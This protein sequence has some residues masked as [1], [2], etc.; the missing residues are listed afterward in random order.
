MA[1]KVGGFYRAALV[2]ADQGVLDAAAQLVDVQEEL[3]VWR[4][5]L[6]A[7]MGQPGPEDD[8]VV[9]MKRATEMILKLMQL[10]SRLANVAGDTL[11]KK[12]A[13]VLEEMGVILDA[14]P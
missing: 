7:A 8:D 14:N 13:G 11:G 1:D 3:A 9:G 12:L 6:R 10:Q 4:V 2:A 5:V